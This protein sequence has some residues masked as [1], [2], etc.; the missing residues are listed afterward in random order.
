MQG[1]HAVAGGGHHAFYLVV[2]ALGEGEQQA[3]RIFQFGCG[4]GYGFVVV[5]QQHA[6]AQSSTQ[7]FAGRVLERGAVKFGHM[8]LGRGLAVVE[9][10]VVGDE[11]H[12]GG[13]G[14]EPADG[15]RP[16]GA[17]V[18]G[19]QGKHAGVV[20][21]FVRGFITGGFVQQDVVVRQGDGGNLFA[22]DG[23]ALHL[24]GLD[25]GIGLF[26]GFA[27]DFN[28]ALFDEPAALLAAA[29]ALGL[30]VFGQLHGG[31]IMGWRRGL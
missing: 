1:F 10:A 22:V 30:Q 19:Q 6:L 21:R 5:V 17:D 8:V 15:L 23:E 25:V 27:V 12:A 18:V 2:F 28:A 29:D 26:G 31:R 16:G 9:R 13:V 3:V 11:Q 14:I 7:A 20:A 24:G 4:G